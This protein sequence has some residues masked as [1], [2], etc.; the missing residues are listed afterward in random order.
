MAVPMLLTHAVYW[1][2]GFVFL[3]LDC[4]SWKWWR[5]NKCQPRAPPMPWRDVRHIC[6]VVAIQLLTVYPMA[7]WLGTPLMRSRLQ[8]DIPSLPDLQTTIG[9]F[10]FFAVSSEAYFYHVHYA[11]H[12]PRLYP[13][14]H[15]LH[16]RYTAPISLECLYFHPLES[17]LQL[18]TVAFGPLLLGSHVL[19]LWVWIVVTLF[20][21][22]LHHCGHEVPL[23][24]APGLGSMSHQHDFHHKAFNCNFG[25][26]G[27]CDYLYGTR[28]CLPIAPAHTLT[29]THTHSLSLTH[30]HVTRAT[31]HRRVCRRCI[32]RLARQVGGRAGGKAQARGEQVRASRNRLVMETPLRPRRRVTLHLTV[33]RRVL[34]DV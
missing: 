34:F 30:V 23:D 25:V 15:K 2:F 3:G 5:G 26:I 28:A 22:S 31:H 14:V 9:S 16:H 32:R 29:H 11:L 6:A 10:A 24:E 33:V 20:N 8:Y 18:G 21:V 17:V 1:I 13:Y 7:I 27:V 19:L 4:S 12:H